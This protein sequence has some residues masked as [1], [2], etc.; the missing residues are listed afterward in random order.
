MV[1]ACGIV[2]VWISVICWKNQV[3]TI[4]RSLD[5]Q[6]SNHDNNLS[7]VLIRLH[8]TMGLDDLVEAEAAVNDGPQ[9]AFFEPC[10]EVALGSSPP[11]GIAQD[12]AYG[13]ASHRQGL[14]DSLINREE[15]R[16]RR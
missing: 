2:I 9:C 12:L 5:F 11:F 16:V 13:I 3:F 10:A 4:W 7:D 14:P 1:L 8:E 15:G 6:P